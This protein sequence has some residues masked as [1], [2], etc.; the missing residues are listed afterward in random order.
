MI[1]AGVTPKTLGWP[2]RCRT[3]FYAHGGKLDPQTGEIIEQASLKEATDALLEAIQAAKAGAFLPDR[4][5]DEL[6]RALKNPEHPGQTR[7][8]G[9]VPW[10]QRFLEWKDT[11]RSR[12]RNK[13]KDADRLADLEAMLRRQQ[14]QIDSISQQRTSQQQ[15]EGPQADPAASARK[16]SVGS[17]HQVEEPAA[18]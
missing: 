13:K 4:E 3:W 9:V 2:D 12:Q 10:L 7:G 1:A 5:N 16:N 15:L 17:T 14:E 18:H 6:T 8:K 11:Y